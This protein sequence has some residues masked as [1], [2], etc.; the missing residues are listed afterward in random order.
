[1]KTNISI[2]DIDKMMI[3]VAHAVTESSK[4]ESYKFLG[5]PTDE[6]REQLLN[7]ARIRLEKIMVGEEEEKCG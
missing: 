1:M 5:E 4:V 3:A 2:K 6:W 7:L